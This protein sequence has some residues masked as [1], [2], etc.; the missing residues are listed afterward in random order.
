MPRY[1]RPSGSGTSTMSRGID[2]IETVFATGS[3]DTTIIVSVSAVVRPTPESMPISSTLTRGT[4]GV[5]DGRGARL[6]RRA[7]RGRGIDG[8]VGVVGL[9][10]R[11]GLGGHP[12]AA[13]ADRREHLLGR[14][15]GVDREAGD[16]ELGAQHDEHRDRERGDGRRAR[17]DRRDDPRRADGE[18]PPAEDE[19][20]DDEDGR[21]HLRVEHPR[22]ERGRV[23]RR[24]EERRGSGA[25][26]RSGRPAAAP[27]ASGRRPGGRDRGRWR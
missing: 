1:L 11:R 2:A 17:R 15:P 12:R 5:A 3:S 26:R 6:G 16:D 19:R 24:G 9:D 22:R 25:A 8:E 20:L 27:T 23:A 18:Q 10:R 13:I 7:G 21:Q 4:V 14:R